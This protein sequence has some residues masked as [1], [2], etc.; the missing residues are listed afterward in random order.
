MAEE[1]KLVNVSGRAET[2]AAQS[3]EVGLKVLENV[4]VR[5]ATSIIFDWRIKGWIA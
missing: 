4:G 2:R 3:F 5:G 1:T